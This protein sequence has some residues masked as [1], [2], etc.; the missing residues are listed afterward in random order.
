M[1]CLTLN[2]HQNPHVL[3][4]CLPVFKKTCKKNQ[5]KT[6][7]GTS[8]SLPSYW[9]PLTLGYGGGKKDGE[10]R[11]SRHPL[12]WIRT[13][14]ITKQKTKKAIKGSLTKTTTTTSMPCLVRKTNK[15]KRKKG[16][17]MLTTCKP[18]DGL[19]GIITVCGLFHMSQDN[20]A[21]SPCHPLRVSLPESWMSKTCNQEGSTLGSWW[22][23][24]SRGKR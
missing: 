14:T 5:N 20:S 4:L 10:N 17:H 11:S 24:T 3:I 22:I 19:K 21:A 9:V 1:F 7:E 15:K 2:R 8:S 12:I 23:R 16:A 18:R 6:V 13:F